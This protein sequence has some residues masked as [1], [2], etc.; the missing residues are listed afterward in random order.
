MATHRLTA[1][2]RENELHHGHGT[3]MKA[4]NTVLY[5]NSN[6][7]INLIIIITIIK[8]LLKFKS[9]LILLSGLNKKTMAMMT[10]N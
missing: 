10:L 5:P 8:H 6:Y 3:M 4:Q 1:R 9:Q 7:I 2:N